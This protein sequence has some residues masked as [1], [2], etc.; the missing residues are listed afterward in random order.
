M[1]KVSSQDYRDAMACLGAAVTIVTTD[2]PAGRAGFTA[3]AVCSVTD[4][5][6]ILLVCLNRG[7]SAYASVKGNGVVC[8]NV[9]SARHEPLSRQFGGGIPVDERFSV[10]AGNRR[11]RSTESTRTFSYT[12][13]GRRSLFGKA[14]G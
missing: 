10:D 2:G 5:S 8:V 1:T 13:P 6:P 12:Y 14:L 9:L 11:A 4:N 7:S 3:S